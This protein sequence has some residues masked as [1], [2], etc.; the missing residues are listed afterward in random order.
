MGRWV[1]V[2]P[3]T[4]ERVVSSY[5]YPLTLVA[6]LTVVSPAIVFS[7]PL[8]LLLLWPAI[9]WRRKRNDRTRLDKPTLVLLAAGAAF[10][11]FGVLALLA[12]SLSTSDRAPITG[13]GTVLVSSSTTYG[14]EL[15]FAVAVAVVFA[16]FLAASL[17]SAKRLWPASTL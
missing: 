12:S 9:Q 11:A 7:V 5:L 3:Y 8:L 1:V 16:P 10:A 2:T 14:S 4:V 6:L 15:L 17:L 13:E